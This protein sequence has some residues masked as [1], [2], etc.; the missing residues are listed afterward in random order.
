MI[1]REELLKTGEYWFETIQN[2]IYRQVE[3]YLRENNLTQSQ[4][5][6]KLGVTKG[7]VSQILN[8]NYN[9]TLKKLIEL[10]LAID[11]APVLDFQYLNEYIKEDLQK[12]YE[13]QYNPIFNLTVTQNRISLISGSSSNSVDV[14]SS[15]NYLTISDAA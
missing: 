5:A 14:K 12:R 6:E 9:A 7:Y 8:G 3:V 15:D 2:E 1:T 11:I 4:F 10:S 13:M